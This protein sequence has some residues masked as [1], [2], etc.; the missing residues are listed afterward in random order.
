MVGGAEMDAAKQAADKTTKP[1]ASN[2]QKLLDGLSTEVDRMSSVFED[3]NRAREE[4]RKRLEEIHNDTMR[5]IQMTRD[6]MLQKSR[7]VQDTMRS[8]TAKFNHELDGM[9]GELRRELAT[10]SSKIEGLIAELD[11]R[12][13]ELEVGLQQ[14]IQERK[15]QTENI[16]GPIRD[17]VDKLTADLEGE[18]EERRKVEE[19]MEKRLADETERLNKG[20]DAEKFSR[21]RQYMAFSSFAEDAQNQLAKRQYEVENEIGDTVRHLSHDLRVET[22]DRKACQDGIAESIASFVQKFQQQLSKDSGGRGGPAQGRSSPTSGAARSGT[23][24]QD[25]EPSESQR[26]ASPEAAET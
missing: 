22:K 14:Q 26:A 4:Y 6:H 10:K 2:G 7:H 16:L 12:T 23:P 1:R 24:S 21:E 20:L 15:K 13:G 3:A 19:G 18:Q 9:R 8:F 5:Q 11:A 25:G 17:E